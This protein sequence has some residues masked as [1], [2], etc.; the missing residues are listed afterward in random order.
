MGLWIKKPTSMFKRI[1]VFL[2]LI[3]VLGCANDNPITSDISFNY[4]PTQ[5]AEKWQFGESDAITIENLKI[6]LSENEI[7]IKKI[8]IS[9]PDVQI[10]CAACI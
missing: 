1:I 6:Y 10:Y 7:E 4:S 5:C 2:F 3:V 9:K 8:S